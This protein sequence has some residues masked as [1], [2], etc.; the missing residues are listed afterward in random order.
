M[1][2]AN[3]VSLRDVVRRDNTAHGRDAA[4]PS[5]PCFV[6]AAVE[7]L[8]WRGLK[9]E[10]LFRVAG[11]GTAVKELTQRTQEGCVECE[12]FADFSVHVVASMLKNFFRELP[13]CLMMSELYD[14][15]IEVTKLEEPPKA[16]HTRLKA[17]IS[18]LPPENQAVMERLFH[19]LQNI[20]LNEQLTRMTPTNVAVVWG[21]TLLWS[22]NSSNATDSLTNSDNVITVVSELVDNYREL[23]QNSRLTAFPDAPALI[24][25]KNYISEKSI[26]GM[27]YL[28]SKVW[29]VDTQGGV[30]LMD[31]KTTTVTSSFDAKQGRVLALVSDGKHAWIGSAMSIKVW[32][33]SCELLREFPGVCCSMCVCCPSGVASQGPEHWHRVFAGGEQLIRIFDSGTLEC[34]A[35]VVLLPGTG[36]VFLSMAHTGERVLLGGSD[37]SVH[38]FDPT[39]A[40]IVTQV[41][42]LQ[43]RRK[44]SVLLYD[45]RNGTFWASTGL[46]AIYIWDERSM[47]KVTELVTPHVLYMAVVED[48]VWTASWDGSV[49]VWNAVTFEHLFEL[50]PQG[51]EAASMLLANWRR[52]ETM[53]QV[54]MCVC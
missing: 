54:P 11:S 40:T 43:K 39:T 41:K 28:G 17:L 49:H 21:P 52:D 2:A 53:W 44:V 9:E 8:L 6:L 20:T 38:V 18:K 42:L 3:A 5:P 35:S 16:I 14:Q 12:D 7:S 29:T 51:S 45:H 48:S 31:D 13:D 1:A 32:S 19:L 22:A 25:R 36:T 34:L 27:M 10:G 15:W 30:F 46:D 24:Y 4:S 26:L 23:F 33:E 50:K 47:T 37:G